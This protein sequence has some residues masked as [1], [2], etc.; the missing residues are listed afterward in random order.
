VAGSAVEAGTDTTA[1]TV[2]W[3]F[4]AVIIYPETFKRAQEEIDRVVGADGSTMPTF[5]SMNDLPYCFALTKEIFRWMPSAPG[6]FPH[7]SDRDDEY[8]GYFIRGKTM[9]IPNI[10]SMHRN[11][12]DFPDSAKFMPERY[13]KDIVYPIKST[14]LTEGHYGFGFGRRGCPGKYLA[15]QTI[16]IAL[17]RLIW[18]FNITNARDENGRI[19][20]P[21]VNHSSNGITS[22]PEEFPFQ[23][24]PRS[25]THEETMRREMNDVFG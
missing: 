9:V 7:Y 25:P 10:W 23:I 20:R 1:A 5:K 2:L 8:N 12:T 6:G 16:W 14:A 15:G 18:G 24:T 17:V 19:I 11:E 21:D 22:K 13:L 4:M 3:F